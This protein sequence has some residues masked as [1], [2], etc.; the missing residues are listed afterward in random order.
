MSF[1]ANVEVTVVD[2]N[3]PHWL[4]KLAARLRK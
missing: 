1:L 3:A 4:E 2:P